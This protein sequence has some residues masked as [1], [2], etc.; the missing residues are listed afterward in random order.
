MHCLKID[1]SLVRD[2]P[3]DV[4]D[5]AICR[6]V[7][8]LG[9]SLGIRIIA[10]GVELEEQAEFLRRIYCD[11]LQGYLYGRP[12]PAAEFERVLCAQSN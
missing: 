6:A 2:I 7:V 1:R 9:H 5:Q 4:N 12:M 11:E 3:D 10:E 8:A